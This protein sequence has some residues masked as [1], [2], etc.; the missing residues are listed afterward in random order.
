MRQ[1]IPARVNAGI[2]KACNPVVLTHPIVT[3]IA[4]LAAHHHYATA[5]GGMVSADLRGYQPSNASKSAL[6]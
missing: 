3:L 6:L 5:P 1:T 2:Q 4:L